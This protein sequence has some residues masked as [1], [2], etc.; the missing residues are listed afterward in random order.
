MHAAGDAVAQAPHDQNDAYRAVVS[1][2][3]S[4]V[5]HIQ[6]SL[7]LIEQMIARET[8]AETSAETSPETS[9]GSS[10]SSINVIVLDDVSPRYMKAAAAVQACDVNLGI[11][12]RSLLDAGDND[13]CASSPPAL[14]VIG[15]VRPTRRRPSGALNRPKPLPFRWDRN[16]ALDF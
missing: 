2:L 7:R 12:L 10:E 13:P 5:E 8:S 6:N 1:D 3:I 4:L 14:A 15:G 11:A 9:P 16:S